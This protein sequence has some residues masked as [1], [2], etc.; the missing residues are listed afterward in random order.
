MPRVP[1]TSK[2]IA[3]EDLFLSGAFAPASVQR[4]YQWLTVHCRDL[5]A[6]ID[7]TFASSSLAPRDEEAVSTEEEASDERVDA[8]LTASQPL[9]TTQPLD[10]YMLGAMVV[11]PPQDGRFLVYDGLQRLT[12]LTVLMSVL[13][14]LSKTAAVRDR[15]DLL[16]RMQSGQ[17]RVVL[18]GKDPTLA[19]QIQPRGEAIRV[20][21]T[22]ATSDMG[23][24][25]RIAAQVFREGLKPWDNERRDAFA[26]FL[27]QH[28]HVDLQT[29]DD[30]RLARQI[31]VTTN[32]RGEPLDRVDLLKGQLV[33][34]ADDETTA[35]TVVSNWNAA[36]AIAGNQFERLLTAVDMI[37]RQGPQSEDHLSALAE[38]V[39]LTRGANGVAAFTQRI[40]Q[41]AS[42]MA[43]LDDLFATP[44][45]DAFAASVWRLQLIRWDTWRPLAL[46]WFA[47]YRRATQ[48]PNAISK[49]KIETAARRFGALHRRCVAMTLAGFSS[50]DRER[51]FAR[52]IGQASRGE[53]PLSSSG[54][55]AFSDV[56]IARIGESLRT[57]MTDKDVRLTVVRWLESMMYREQVPTHVRE[58][59]VEHIL[60]RRPAA[61]SNWVLMFP[62]PE[63][64]YMAC[65]AFGNLAALDKARN[66]GLRN[67]DFVA[68]RIVLSEAAADYKTLADVP[69]TG[70]WT[71]ATI[72]A[73]TELLAKQVETALEL[74]PAFTGIRRTIAHR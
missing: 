66:E 20:R 7:R 17:F 28:V 31:F 61:G 3:V 68:K 67:A 18:P 36:R 71:T 54:A 42:D 10:H 51:I 43:A 47:D 19:R 24:R 57:P 74:P 22:P 1:I 26:A 38:H 40:G 32:M 73:R 14:D 39:A 53:N 49:R 12:T 50:A 25:V 30:A 60:P 5:L 62:D 52:A 48:N 33:D 2:I 27:L 44:P 72:E 29:A 35:A 56:Q 41:L 59:T 23:K 55:L 13:R 8:D 11:T 6:D 16:I 63:A 65:N 21:R 9:Q 45:A 58:A 46:L 69:A 37:E 70:D 15:L 64:R 4:D 34:I